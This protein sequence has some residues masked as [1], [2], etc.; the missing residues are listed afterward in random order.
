MMTR[1]E[2][3][4]A[5]MAAFITTGVAA[6]ILAITKIQVYYLIREGRLEYID[7]G[8]GGKQKAYRIKSESV[9]RKLDGV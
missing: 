2:I 8:A 6:A 7:V 4:R 9:R 5:L 1:E 3:D